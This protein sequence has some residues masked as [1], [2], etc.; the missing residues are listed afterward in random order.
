[1]NAIEVRP[2]IEANPGLDDFFGPEVTGQNM[3][4]L[5]AAEQNARATYL[6]PE[7]TKG[8]LTLLRPP[9]RGVLNY[10]QTDGLVGKAIAFT[11]D[12]AD[13]ISRT[14]EDV[15]KMA[16]IAHMI[17]AG[18]DGHGGNANQANNVVNISTF[19]IN[20]GVEF[21]KHDH[22]EHGKEKNDCNKCKAA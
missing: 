8:N 10:N 15:Q 5:K 13:F 1:M 21:K 19:K 7:I 6:K 22:C 14:K 20:K 4:F 9:L 16:M 17:C 18:M 12:N 2:N 11:R 3:G